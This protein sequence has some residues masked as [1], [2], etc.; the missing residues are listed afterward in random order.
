MIG[1]DGAIIGNFDVKIYCFGTQSA[2]PS[3]FLS[4][5]ALSSL[6]F[7][8]RQYSGYYRLLVNLICLCDEPQAASLKGETRHVTSITVR[9]RKRE[10]TREN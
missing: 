4:L 3:P 6:S 8:R 2:P 10:R 1:G 5:P 7:P 9:E